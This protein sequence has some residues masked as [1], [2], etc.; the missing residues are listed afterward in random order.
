MQRWCP[1]NYTI[2]YSIYCSYAIAASKFD[3]TSDEQ[4]K[5]NK[6]NLDSY[7][8]GITKLRPVT[9]THKDKTKYGT[10]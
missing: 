3:S 1:A 6:E 8:D 5:T 10:S 9:F 2:T 4:I 7:L